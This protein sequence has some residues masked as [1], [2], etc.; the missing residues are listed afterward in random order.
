MKK[1]LERFTERLAV[2]LE[3]DGLPR[4]AGRIFALLLVSPDAR[5]LDDLALALGV[6]KASVSTNVRLLEAR[7][8]FERVGRPGD[9]RDYYRPAADLL[10]RTL[11]QRLLRWQRFH[12]TVAE[13]RHA[14]DIDSAVVRRRFERLDAGHVYITSVVE[15]A[16]SEWKRKH[17]D[18]IP[19]RISRGV[20]R[21]S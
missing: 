6:S 7:G 16:L 11:E 18:V 10:V 5:S 2:V 8:L 21:G 3:A 19:A 20:K 4:I 9:R 17:A 14:L 13:G 15:H 12:E 1:T